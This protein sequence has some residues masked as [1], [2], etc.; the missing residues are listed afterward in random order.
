MH[1]IDLKK[2]LVRM[3]TVFRSYSSRG[4]II[5]QTNGMKNCEVGDNLVVATERHEILHI[6]VFK[7]L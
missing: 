7:I 5:Q 2:E 6:Y 1:V 4:N 3:P